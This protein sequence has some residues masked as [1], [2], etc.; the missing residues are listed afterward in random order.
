M[1]RLKKKLSKISKLHRF[2]R[3]VIRGSLQFT[4]VLYI[5]AFAAYYLAPHTPD[6]FRAMAYSN[7]ALE[8]A[9]VTLGAG[10]IAALISDLGY[11]PQTQSPIRPG[12]DRHRALRC[13]E[14]RR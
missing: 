11:S 4:L 2:S 1:K 10:I 3:N 12:A 9:P 13:P 14:G 8:I 6:Y 7:A 5:F